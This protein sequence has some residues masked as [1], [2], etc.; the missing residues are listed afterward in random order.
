MIMKQLKTTCSDTIIAISPHLP[1][2]N[3]RCETGEILVAENDWWTY[4]GGDAYCF[5][6]SAVY[7]C[8]AVRYLPEDTLPE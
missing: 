4:N 6:G 8:K 7:C 3:G 5:S 1:V 2:C